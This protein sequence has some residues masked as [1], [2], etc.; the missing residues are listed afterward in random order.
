MT[1]ACN[2]AMV[3]KTK[4]IR[5][6]GNGSNWFDAAENVLKMM[7]RNSRAEKEMIKLQLPPNRATLSEMLG[8]L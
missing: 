6:K 8:L 1:G 7:Q 3:H 5:M 2:A 4:F